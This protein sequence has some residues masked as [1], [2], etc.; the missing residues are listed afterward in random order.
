MSAVVVVILRQLA[1]PAGP[2]ATCAIVYLPADAAPSAIFHLSS[3]KYPVAAPNPVSDVER[4]ATC[5]APLYTMLR[6]PPICPLLIDVAPVI[7]PL[8]AKSP[9]IVTLVV[10]VGMPRTVASASL[11][12]VTSLVEP[13]PV[14]IAPSTLV[15]PSAALSPAEVSPSGSNVAA[16]ATAVTSTDAS[17]ELPETSKVAFISTAVAFNSISSVALI[18]KTVAVGAL[19]YCEA[20]LN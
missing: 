19:M 14:K 18:S 16:V 5:I 4:C 1:N 3:V 12:R 11:T 9:A 15:Y 10:P 13:C 8:T 17:T 20:S 2:S 7:P 6:L